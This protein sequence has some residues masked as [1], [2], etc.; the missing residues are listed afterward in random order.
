MNLKNLNRE[1]QLNQN[2]I[3]EIINLYKSGKL[4]DQ[5]SKIENCIKKFP[6][7]F[8]LFNIL[9]SFLIVC[10]KPS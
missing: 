6:K 3:E 4:V 9:K 2:I 1:T 8:V 5:K 10:A 7:S